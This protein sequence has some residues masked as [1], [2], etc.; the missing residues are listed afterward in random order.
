MGGV[1]CIN[2]VNNGGSDTTVIVYDIVGRQV[3]AERVGAESSASI[4]LPRGIYLAVGKKL[5]VK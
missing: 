1:G 5:M 2:V 4:T 3:A